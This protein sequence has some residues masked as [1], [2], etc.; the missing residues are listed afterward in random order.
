M[1]TV[2]P[3]HENDM[4]PENMTHLE[5]ARELYTDSSAR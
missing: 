3:F 4:F 2:V 5:P 1:N